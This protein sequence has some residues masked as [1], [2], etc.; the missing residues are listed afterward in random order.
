MSWKFN[1][2]FVNACQAEVNDLWHRQLGH[3]NQQAL[4][5]LVQQNM[6]EGIGTK[7]NKVGFCEPCVQGKQCL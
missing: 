3:I 7:P 4:S 5:K 2:P 6:V 1:K